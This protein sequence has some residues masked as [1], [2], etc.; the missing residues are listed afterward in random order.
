[1][2]KLTI[3]QNILDWILMIPFVSALVIVV[4][5]IP[6]VTIF[7]YIGVFLSSLFHEKA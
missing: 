5:I 3:K 6:I 1:M 7:L 2:R 4:L